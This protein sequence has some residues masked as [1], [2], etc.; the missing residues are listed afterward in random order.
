MNVWTADICWQIAFVDGM[1]CQHVLVNQHMR[2]ACPA[3]KCWYTDIVYF[4]N[5]RSILFFS[6][7]FQ[8]SSLCG[9]SLR[10]SVIG[11]MT[12]ST[13]LGLGSGLK[14]TFVFRHG[15]FMCRV[16]GTLVLFLFWH[17]LSHSRFF[18]FFS[19]I[20]TRWAASEAMLTATPILTLPQ[21]KLASRTAASM[22]RNRK[23]FA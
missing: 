19:G 3:S 20:G 14:T 12:T 2:T 10:Y 1:R 8:A 7:L 6:L 13:Q 18:V 4:L 15:S 9:Q 5:L 21:L 11:L 23:R 22:V 16:T 17:K